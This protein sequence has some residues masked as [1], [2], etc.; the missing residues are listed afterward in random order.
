MS[1]T[2]RVFL[3]G[4]QPACRPS[5]AVFHV[6]SPIARDYLVFSRF[7]RRRVLGL[8]VARLLPSRSPCS[9]SLPH[10]FL[11]F[12]V[13]A[14][15]PPLSPR[16]PLSNDYSTTRRRRRRS[17]FG[18]NG[19]SLFSTPLFLER[20]LINDRSRALFV[21]NREYRIASASRRVASRRR[22][23]IVLINK[24]A[25]RNLP[26]PTRL[27]SVSFH[28]HCPRNVETLLRTIPTPARGEERKFVWPVLAATRSVFN[29]LV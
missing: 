16:F 15:F 7:H 28:R 18:G 11:A 25:R 12:Q 14:F 6:S 1:L 10:H 21:I 17:F 20:L 5:F 19:R 23:A 22:L 9:V 29:F 24:R 13:H 3:S 8:T 26:R 2:H 27:S 4:F